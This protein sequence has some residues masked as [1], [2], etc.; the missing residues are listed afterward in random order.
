MCTQKQKKT[1]HSLAGEE[2]NSAEL[3]VPSLIFCQQTSLI[4]EQFPELQLYFYL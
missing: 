1:K 3:D 4:L 2:K